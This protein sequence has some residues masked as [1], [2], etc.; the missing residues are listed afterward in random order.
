VKKS[1]FIILIVITSIFGVVFTGFGASDQQRY[2]GT[3]VQIFPNGPKSLSYYPEMGPGDSIAA[4]PAAEKLMEYNQ[5]KQLVPFLAESVEIGQDGKSIIFKL[6]KGIKFHD[7]SD[8]NAEAAAWNYQLAKDTHRLQYDNKLVSIE[9][10][11]PYTMKLNLTDY[12]NQLIHS[13]GWVP[14]FSKA[15]WDKAG[16]GDQEKSKAWARVNIVATGPFK[17]AEFKRD[18]EMKWV[19]NEN[20]WKPGKPYLNSIVYRFIPDP[21]TASS[22]MQA[23]E[24]DWWH[25]APVKDQAELVKKGFVRQEGYGLPRMIYINNKDPNSKFRDKRLREAIEYAL[26]KPTMAKALGFGYFTPLTMVAP[27]GEWG[28]DPK[29]T[30]R[31]FNPEK[32]K[33]LLAEAGYPEGLKIKLMALAVGSWPDE[34]EA[35]AAYLRDIGIDVK[36][37]LADPGRFFSSLWMK[38]WDDLILFLTGMDPNYLMTFHRQFGPQPMSNYASF[39]RPPVLVKPAEASLLLESEEEQ[40][41]MTKKLVRIMADECL[42]IPLYLSPSAYIIQPYVHTTFLKEQ[43]VA[44]YTEDEWME[45]H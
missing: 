28:Y 12:N 10:V 6:R 27:P 1:L 30:G 33:Q 23:G 14:I 26:D 18:V 16:G 2:G 15:A 5:K 32:A 20:Y 8:F 13:F 4:L 3:L 17:L 39:E 38:G 7:G 19:R 34:A 9:V 31:A 35:V 29:Y 44:R 40:I 25:Q 43:M 11:D 36:V 22:I 42:V 45:D 41:A 37:D 24:A 21:T